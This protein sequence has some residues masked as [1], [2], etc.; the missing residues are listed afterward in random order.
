MDIEIHLSVYKV[1]SRHK[2]Y[3][4]T[5]DTIKTHLHKSRISSAAA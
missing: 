3:Q 4:R 1:I 2:D 5:G